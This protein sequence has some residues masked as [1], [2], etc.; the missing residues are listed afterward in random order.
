MFF[1]LFCHCQW[2]TG[3]LNL[4]CVFSFFFAEWCVCRRAWNNSWGGVGLVPRVPCSQF[5]WNIGKNQRKCIGRIYYGRSWMEKVWTEYGFDRWKRANRFDTN[6]STGCKRQ[7]YMLLWI[8]QFTAATNTP[9][10]TSIEIARF[11]HFDILQ[12]ST[13]LLFQS[14]P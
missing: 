1:I 9:W 7:K 6:R 12:Q 13:T 3:T 10:S 2:L 14:Q 8:E 4:M 11:W 5:Y